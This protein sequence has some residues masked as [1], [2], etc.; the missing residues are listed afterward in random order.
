MTARP[1]QV[2]TGPYIVLA[3]LFVFG[4][5]GACNTGPPDGTARPLR[6]TW[7]NDIVRI[8]GTQVRRDGEWLKEGPFIFRDDQGAVT[9]SGMYENGL[10]V[11]V[12]SERYEDG[13]AGSGPYFEGNRHGHWRYLHANGKVFQEG[14]YRAGERIGTWTH[15]SRAGEPRPSLVYED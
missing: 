3:C 6:Q 10:E 5:F 14:E 7:P 1:S 9:F 12:W 8:E 11:G 15:L 13:G 2:R 4:A